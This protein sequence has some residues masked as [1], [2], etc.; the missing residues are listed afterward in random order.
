MIIGLNKKYKKILFA[1]EDERVLR[2]KHHLYE[3]N[4]RKWIFDR[5]KE[6]DIDY[7]SDIEIF[8]THGITQN[9]IINDKNS[10]DL[11]GAEKGHSI[12]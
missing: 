10:F 7:T 9:Q 6:F 1:I 5:L 2:R 8:D 11:K 3:G 12:A 4:S